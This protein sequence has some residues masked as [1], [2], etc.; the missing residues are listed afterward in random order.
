[1]LSG[2]I[3]LKNNHYYYYRYRHHSR[4]Y[5]DIAIII[6]IYYIII[7]FISITNNLN[8]EHFSSGVEHSTIRLI[9]ITTTKTNR[10]KNCIEAS[11]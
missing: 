1:M 4:C 8:D 2:E 7:I 6:I 3:A 5:V 11:S 9:T 10:L